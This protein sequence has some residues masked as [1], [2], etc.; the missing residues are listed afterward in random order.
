[1]KPKVYRKAEFSPICSTASDGQVD[2][3]LLAANE[4]E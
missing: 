2:E 4:R 3:K 1:M